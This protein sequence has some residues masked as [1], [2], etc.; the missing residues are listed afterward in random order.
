MS[1]LEC[2]ARSLAKLAEEDWDR[3]AAW[4][5]LQWWLEAMRALMAVARGVG[6]D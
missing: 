1:N 2:C 5:R 6:K 3:L 4:P